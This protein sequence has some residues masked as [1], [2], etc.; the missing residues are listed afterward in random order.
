MHAAAL[1]LIQLQVQWTRRGRRVRLSLYLPSQWA[2][3]SLSDS[4]PARTPA[5]LGNVNECSQFNLE[6]STSQAGT[7]VTVAWYTRIHIWIHETYEFINNNKWIHMWIHIWIHI[8]MNS[9]M[10]SY[11]NSYMKCLYELWIHIWNDYMKWL[12][13]FIVY[14][15]HT[16]YMSIKIHVYEFKCIDS[17]FMSECI[18]VL[19]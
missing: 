11:M 17:V 13:E 8:W 7:L 5:A 1:R 4:A 18:S 10:I 2:A 3:A 15:N 19:H 14:M 16:R 12:Y 9:Y 6:L